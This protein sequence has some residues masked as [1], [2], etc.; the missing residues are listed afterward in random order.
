MLWVMID[1]NLITYFMGDDQFYSRNLVVD[2][3]DFVVFSPL[4][5]PVT[6]FKTVGW[7]RTYIFVWALISPCSIVH[8]VFL[9]CSLFPLLFSFLQKWDKIKTTKNIPCLHE[10]SSLFSEKGGR[11]RS[12]R[13]WKFV[14]NALLSLF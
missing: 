6:C 8:E 1:F 11:L 3:I 12:Y 2:V 9:F 13:S 14:N 10:N 5:E 4:S 7:S